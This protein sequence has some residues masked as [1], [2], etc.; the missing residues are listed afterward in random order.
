MHAVISP[1]KS[2]LR[3]ACVGG[4]IGVLWL[5]GCSH[6]DVFS[7]RANSQDSTLTQGANRQLTYNVGNDRRPA[8]LPD[9][10]GMLFTW[11]DLG[12]DDKDN[13]LVRLP[14]TGG[15]IIQETC[16]YTLGSAD[17]IDTFI[18][19]APNADGRLLYAKESSVETS[20]TP[21]ESALVLATVSSPANATIIRPYPY[22]APNGKIHLGITDVRWI[23]PT[24]ALYLAQQIFY[25]S[26]CSRCPRD[27]V[28]MGLELVKLDLATVT[29]ALTIVPNSQDVSSVSVNPTDGTVYITRNG[30]TRVFS[31]DLATGAVAI[32][33]DFGLLGIVRDVS[34]VGTRMMAVVGGRVSYGPDPVVG[35]LQRDAAGALYEVNLATGSATLLPVLDRLFRRPALSPDGQ[36]G[37]AEAYSAH[38]ASCAPPIGC[39]D[40]TITSTAD[41]WLFDLP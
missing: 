25:L 26:P 29:P 7:G 11:E 27:T 34:V 23:D 6:G 12:R 37:V 35:V 5:V 20:L 2:R 8:W 15:T 38:V 33:H 31:I 10:S 39:I 3:R 36:H 22:T 32:V 4:S 30:D 21:N 18:E 1:R 16:G 17:S 24:T 13:C 40:T 28:R 19:A 9:G 41:L 14:S